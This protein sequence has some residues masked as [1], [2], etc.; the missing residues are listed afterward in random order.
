MVSDQASF[1]AHATRDSPEDHRER[2]EG[3][4]RHSTGLV[5]PS[6]SVRSVRVA[7]VAHDQRHQ[8]TSLPLRRPRHVLGSPRRAARAG[9]PAACATSEWPRQPASAGAGSQQLSRRHVILSPEEGVQ[10]GTKEWLV[11]RGE[12]E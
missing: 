11:W 10:S 8:R 2:H 7:E 4:T 3:V 6:S 12:F 1:V 9:L 5:A